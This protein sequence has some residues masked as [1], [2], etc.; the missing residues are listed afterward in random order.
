MVQRS[1]MCPFMVGIMAHSTIAVTIHGHPWID[2]PVHT[3]LWQYPWASQLP[4]PSMTIHGWTPLCIALVTESMDVTVSV[5]IH[6]QGGHRCLLVSI[7]QMYIKVTI[8]V[9]KIIICTIKVSEPWNEVI[10]ALWIQ[11]QWAADSK[12]ALRVNCGACLWF[13]HQFSHNERINII[14]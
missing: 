2:T 8:I 10:W 13:I 14:L 7:Y 4:W 3:P 5:T 6:T 9:S 12:W 1:P 11:S